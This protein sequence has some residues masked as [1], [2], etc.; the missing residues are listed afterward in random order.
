MFEVSATAIR[1][2]QGLKGPK[3]QTNYFSKENLNLDRQVPGPRGRSALWGPGCWDGEWGRERQTER[4]VYTLLPRAFG[5][6]V[7]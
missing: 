5:L 6:R 2:H 4:E 3:H 1:C 7:E